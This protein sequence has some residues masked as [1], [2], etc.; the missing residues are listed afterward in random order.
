VGA[1][2]GETVVNNYY[3]DDNFGGG[4]HRDNALLADNGNLDNGL[5]DYVDDSQ[6]DDSSF[7]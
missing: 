6:N 1:A 3:G 2:P 5:D 7:F 4:S